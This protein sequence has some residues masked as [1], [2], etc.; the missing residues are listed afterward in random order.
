[1]TF[2]R[3]DIDYTVDLELGEQRR[4]MRVEFELLDSS[5]KVGLAAFEFSRLDDFVAERPTDRA[6]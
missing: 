4:E 1:L 5:E 2:V 6:H 3:T